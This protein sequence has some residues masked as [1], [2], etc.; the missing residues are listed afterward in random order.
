[1]LDFKH[2]GDILAGRMAILWTGTQHDT[3]GVVNLPRDYERIAESARI[4]RE[5]VL[6][7]DLALLARGVGVY[8]QT[9]LDEGMAPLPEIDGAI[10]RKYCG[11]GYGGYGLYLFDDPALRDIAVAGR[12][13]LRPIEPFCRV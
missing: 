11:G 8:H 1:V 13:H 12:E 10:A 4:A 3:P 6:R 5:G 2:N 9:Q 7:R